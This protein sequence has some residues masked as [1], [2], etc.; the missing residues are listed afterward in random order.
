M[1]WCYQINI[2]KLL[3]ANQQMADSIFNEV[4]FTFTNHVVV[5]L[6]DVGLGV[7]TF[8]NHV[9]SLKD[10]CWTRQGTS[11]ESMDLAR[12]AKGQQARH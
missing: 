3:T 9:V 8:T 1:T 11:Q 5:S 6:K 12:A 7:F 2:K 10:T 4:V